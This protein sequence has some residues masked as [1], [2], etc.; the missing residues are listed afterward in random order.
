MA[1]EEPSMC[2]PRLL[3]S[4]RD[5][6][7]AVEAIDGGCDIL[8][9]KEPNR[10]ALGMSKVATIRDII[11]TVR[12][13]TVGL[14]ESTIPVSAALGEVA[15][16]QHAGTIPR[17]P[18]ELAYVKLGL[19]GLGNDPQWMQKWRQTRESFQQAAGKELNWIAVVYADWQLA[20][21]PSP[22]EIVAAVCHL[23]RGNDTG[24]ALHDK[25]S[26]DHSFAGVLFDT[27]SKTGRH[28]LDWLSPAELLDL[29][30]EIADVGLLT[31]LAGS[32]S[33]RLL[34]DL[35]DLSPEIIAIRGAACD[36]SDR[37]AEVS[38][39]R[40]DTFQSAITSVFQPSIS[41]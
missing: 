22:R 17:I 16:W 21:A 12:N 39:S 19:A 36:A 40:V 27:S 24:E 35:R 4:V 5:A 26:A 13:H 41:L 1:S 14:H 28:L 10:G 37:R 25:G 6:V 23:N 20:L 38:A 18:A 29:R 34:P 30:R 8:D 33:E 32:L 9:I 31:A 7:E 15:D 11:H 2:R 3:V